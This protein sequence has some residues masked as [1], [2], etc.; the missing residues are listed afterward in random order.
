MAIDGKKK[1]QLYLDEENV[2]YLKKH[3]SQRPNAG[4]ISGLVDKYLDRCVIMHKD[5]QDIFDKIEPGKLT[6]KKFFQFVKLQ[7]RMQE[8]NSRLQDQWKDKPDD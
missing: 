7:F 1:Y 4:G 5:N 2:E 3:F 6:L 8:N